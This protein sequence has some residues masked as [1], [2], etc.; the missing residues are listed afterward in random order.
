MFMIVIILAVPFR[1]LLMIATASVLC[2]FIF[3]YQS[4]TALQSV[5]VFSG[6]PDPP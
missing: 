6:T 2:A 4:I 5:P 1:S 3:I